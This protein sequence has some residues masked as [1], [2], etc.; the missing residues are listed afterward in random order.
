MSA[1]SV[2]MTRAAAKIKETESLLSYNPAY[3]DRIWGLWGSHYNM[4][5]AVFYVRKGDS[6]PYCFLVGEGSTQKIMETF[7]GTG[8]HSWV[9]Q[10]KNRQNK[11]QLLDIKL[12]PLNC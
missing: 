6:I 11:L 10:I 3:V 1:M 9:L 5:K 4:P 2:V 12:P 7:V 8:V